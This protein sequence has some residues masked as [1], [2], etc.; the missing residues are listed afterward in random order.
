[1][2]TFTNGV[3]RDFPR[4]NVPR[5][6]AGNEP[7][8]ITK[9]APVN[10]SATIK[11]GQPIALVS[12]EWVQATNAHSSSQIY[13]AYHDSDDTDV[14]SCG[15]LLGFSV[16]G[17]FEIETPWVQTNGLAVG[18][19]LVVNSNNDL[20]EA[21]N[22]A[23]GTPGSD[24][25]GYVTEIRDLGVLG[26][27]SAN[28]RGGVVGTIPEDSTANGAYGLKIQVSD[29]PANSG[30]LKLD[31]FSGATKTWTVD[32]TLATSNATKIGTNGLTTAEE[33]ASA[34]ADAI[35]AAAHAFNAYASGTTVN[36]WQT[37]PGASGVSAPDGTGTINNVTIDSAFTRGPAFYVVKFVTS[38]A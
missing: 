12:D 35:N 32:Q 22:T 15:K 5:G 10:S 20:C 34:I 3:L 7:Q 25:V 28:A 23:G 13:I 18:D 11:S 8:A 29:V 37:A 24:V 21:S 36:V 19:Q 30:T 2:P 27:T 31:D 9:S 1:M 16:L 4:V 33:A 26:H 17:E 6:Y 38:A 14:Q